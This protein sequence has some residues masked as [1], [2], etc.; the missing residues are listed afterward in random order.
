MLVNPDFTNVSIALKEG[1]LVYLREKAT[2]RLLGL[3]N[4]IVCEH[5]FV[6]SFCSLFVD[7]M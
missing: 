2:L 5:C 7:C 1:G 3:N 6:L 4:W